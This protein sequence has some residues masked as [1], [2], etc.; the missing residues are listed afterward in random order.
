MADFTTYQAPGL[1]TE[2]VPGPQ[3]SVQTSTP[4]AVG[5]F[6]QAVGYRTFTESLVI[7]PDEQDEDTL[8]FSPVANRCLLYTSDAADE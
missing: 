1:Y 4:V 3:L 6:G 8:E 5:I 2:A 7:D